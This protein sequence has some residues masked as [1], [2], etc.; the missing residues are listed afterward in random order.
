MKKSKFF[1]LRYLRLIV[2][3]TMSQLVVHTQR[4]LLILIMVNNAVMSPILVRGATP[5]IKKI[6]FTSL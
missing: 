4:N 1:A 5:T 2:P 3:K 6:T